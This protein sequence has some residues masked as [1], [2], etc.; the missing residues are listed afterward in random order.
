MGICSL[1]GWGQVKVDWLHRFP[2]SA[3]LFTLCLDVVAVW[4]RCLLSDGPQDVLIVCWGLEQD[5]LAWGGVL[6]G[7]KLCVPH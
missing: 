5:F 7:L 1:L 2:C 3:I 6:V 4:C